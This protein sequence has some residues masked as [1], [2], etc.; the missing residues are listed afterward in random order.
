MKDILFIRQGLSI[1]LAEIKMQQIRSQGAGG[2]N[3]NK[4]AT[5]VQLFFDIHDSSLP[6]NV[7]FRLL[8][9]PDTRIT[10]DGVIVI[11]AQNNRTYERNREEALARLSKLLQEATVPRK[12]RRPTKPSKISQQKRLDRKTRH[13][14]LKSLRKKIH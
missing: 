4:V 6:E 1:P 3:V 11:K 2:Q 9:H 14:R 5:A 12:K 13:G 7:K 8:H 10:K